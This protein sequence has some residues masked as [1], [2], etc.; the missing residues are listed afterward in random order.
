MPI[1]VPIPA[2]GTPIGPGFKIH[3][4]GLLGPTQTLDRIQ[5]RIRVEGNEI[6]NIIGGCVVANGSTSV[7]TFVGESDGCGVSIPI[8]GPVPGQGQAVRL[9]IEHQNP[10]GERI[11][12][13]SQPQTWDGA[14]QLWMYGNLVGW[15]SATVQ[16][17]FGSADRALLHHVDDAVYQRFPHA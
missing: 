5:W 2:T 8:S 14:A 16:G 7:D 15:G 4:D 12:S 6:E 13:Y 9:Y 1:S 11:E 3:V 17:G 10:A